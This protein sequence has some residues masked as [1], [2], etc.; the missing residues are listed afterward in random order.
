M[1]TVFKIMRLKYEHPEYR[2]ETLPENCK[3]PVSQIRLRWKVV[4]A[5]GDVEVLQVTKRN[6]VEL[7]GAE[8]VALVKEYT[9]RKCP[10]LS[11][12]KSVCVL[13]E[14]AKK[15]AAEE[16]AKTLVLKEKE[17]AP[18][19]KHLLKDEDV[20]RLRVHFPGPKFE[21]ERLVRLECVN[22]EWERWCAEAPERQA[23]HT[24]AM[25]VAKELA[26][27]RKEAKEAAKAKA[28][29][30][31]AKKGKAP[32]KAGGRGRGAKRAGGGGGRGGGRG[33]GRGQ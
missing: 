10:H 27:A 17:E 26:V 19:C 5:S 31:P 20:V 16:G 24:A 25:A 6:V 12:L 11:P 30:A 4:G 14:K 33:R 29:A 15:V 7:S 32:A 23:K 18:P 9:Q 13:P 3:T 28:P 8:I 21:M 1:E 22:D 2:H